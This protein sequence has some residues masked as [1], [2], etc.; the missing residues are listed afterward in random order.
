[1]AGR[2]DPRTLDWKNA[3]GEAGMSQR[4]TIIPVLLLALVPTALRVDQTFAIECSGISHDVLSFEALYVDGQMHRMQCIETETPVTVIALCD[5]SRTRKVCVAQ[6]I[7][8]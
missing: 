1:M 3:L 5:I 2:D 6:E 4:F 7:E 8:R